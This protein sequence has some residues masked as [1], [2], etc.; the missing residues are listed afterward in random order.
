LYQTFTPWIS[1]SVAVLVCGF[2]VWKGDRW[3]RFVAIVY[4][5]GWIATPFATLRDPMSPEW[6]IMAID[7]VV[8]ALLVWASLRSRR[9]WSLFAAACQMMCV[10]SHVVSIIDLRI[11]IATLIAGL[12]LLSYGV[13]IA[14][15]LGTFAAIR[16]RRVTHERD[17]SLRP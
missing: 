3:V 15:L 12:A 13:L 16:A 11:Y 2:A 5:V 1:L 7:V 8:M 9:L 4:L 10:A 6:G 17:I 14:L